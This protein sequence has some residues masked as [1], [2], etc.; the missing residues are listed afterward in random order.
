MT[1]WTICILNFK[2]PKIG[3]ETDAKLTLTGHHYQRHVMSWSCYGLEAM[4]DQRIDSLE[5]RLGRLEGLEERVADLERISQGQNRHG[6]REGKDINEGLLVKIFAKSHFALFVA[7]LFQDNIYIYLLYLFY[8]ILSTF[9]LLPRCVWFSF[10]VSSA[11]EW[12]KR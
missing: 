10:Q 8:H 6:D 12:M 1:I 2:T 3:Q 7:D 9:I 5:I 4:L 11:W